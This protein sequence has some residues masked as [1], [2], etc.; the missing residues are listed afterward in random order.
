MSGRIRDI[1]S[2]GILVKT[3]ASNIVNVIMIIIPISGTYIDTYMRL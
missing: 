1:N 2:E 3:A